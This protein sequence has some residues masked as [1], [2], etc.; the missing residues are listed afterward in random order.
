MK[1]KKGVMKYI[2]AAIIIVVFIVTAALIGKKDNTVSVMAA[3]SD[4]SMGTI[5]TEENVDI[6]A[7]VKNIAE[8]DIEDNMLKDK[9]ELIGKTVSCNMAADS[10]FTSDVMGEEANNRAAM[11]NP[12]VAGVR[13]S[14]ISQ[15]SGGIIRAGDY[16]DISVVDSNTGKCSNVISNVYVTEAFNSD[17]TAI[18]D[19][20]CAMI[21]NVLIEKESEQYLNEM[22][23]TGSIRVCRL[24][25]STDG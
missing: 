1:R 13:A 9:A 20:G 2:I 8:Q 11:I 6:L 18:E 5:I 21:L 24:E 16:I 14:D 15:F 17:G 12:V 19:N 23:A 3:A 4:I 22:L 7:V 25:R 10:I